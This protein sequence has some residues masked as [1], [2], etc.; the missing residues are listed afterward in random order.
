MSLFNGSI[1]SLI[2]KGGNLLTDSLN[3]GNINVAGTTNL[4]GD[5]NI[6]GNLERCAF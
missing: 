1:N 3:S 4:A 6:A 2:L 5:I